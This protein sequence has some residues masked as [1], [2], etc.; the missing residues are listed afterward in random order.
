MLRPAAELTTEELSYLGV[1]IRKSAP[2]QHHVAF[3][4]E[5]PDSSL[6]LSHLEWHR[7]FR[8]YDLWNNQ[9]YWSS[10]DGMEALNRKTVAAWLFALSQNPQ[11]ID[12]G[13]SFE[14][15]EFTQDATGSWA[16]IS[17]SGKGITC[18]T[19]IMLVL[20]TVGFPLLEKGT[21]PAR[22]EDTSW[23]NSMLELLKQHTDMTAADLELVAKDV[24]CVRFRPI[25]VVAAADHG[26]WPVA[27][28]TAVELASVILAEIIDLQLQSE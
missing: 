3:I 6:R 5:A 1:G 20:E 7:R 19:F 2:Q 4:Y 27:Y 17:Q 9:Y 21:W 24:G 16:F 18:A 22:A 28:E 12:Y 11:I 23:Q 8:P 25:E 13:L 26:D 15:C 10:A 14:G